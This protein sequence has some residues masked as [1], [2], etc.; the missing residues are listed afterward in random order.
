MSSCST[1]LIS[2]KRLAVV[3]ETGLLNPQYE[4]AFQQLN[5]LA[6]LIL[7]APVSI[8]SVFGK[9]KQVFKSVVGLPPELGP[10]STFPVDISVCKYA[11]EGKPIQFFDTKNDPLFKENAAVQQL[12]IAGYLGM[13]VITKE[14]QPLGTV[15]VYDTKPREWTE[16]D[17][18][19]LRII[20]NSFLTEVEL[21]IALKRAENEVVKREE[22]MAIAAHEMKNPLTSMKLQTEIGQRKLNRNNFLIEDYQD[23]LSLFQRQYKRINILIDDMFD[24]SRIRSG[25]FTIRKERCDL[26]ELINMLKVNFEQKFLDSDAELIVECE[27]GLSGS[28]DSYRLEQVLS[29]LISNAL[30]YAPGSKAILKAIRNKSSVE[31]SIQDFGPG[32]GPEAQKKLFL[33]FE[34]NAS[35]THING[36]GLGLYISQQIIKEHGGSLSL[37]SDSGKGSKFTIL[38]PLD[39]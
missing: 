16:Q 20:T 36:L 15:C 13:P 4:E 24:A 38:L 14:G 26:S 35:Q 11:L 5:Q 6:T 32:I 10:G 39:S 29:N 33:P 9:D 21:R 3:E 18:E 12:G 34:R 7:K 27:S 23:F 28:W 8:F 2:P 19:C 22:F 1:I 31:I 25:L 30:K 17:I 37:E